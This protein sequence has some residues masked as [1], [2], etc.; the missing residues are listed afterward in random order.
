MQMTSPTSFMSEK[1]GG[2]VA[3]GAL[4]VL[5]VLASDLLLFDVEPGINLFVAAMLI[6][7]ALMLFA[8]R[9]GRL[10]RGVLG[11]ATTL[12][13]ALPLIEAPS[14]LGL[15][16]A[17]LG[18][19]LAALMSMRLVPRR[20][21]Q[22]PTTVMRLLLPAPITLAR[23]AASLGRVARQHS[24]QASLRGLLAWVMPLGLGVVFILLFAA[25]NPL[26]EMALA[27]LRVDS[28]LNLLNPVRIVFWLIM[29][30]GI[31]A[32]LRP[33]LLRWQKIRRE[34]SL[35]APR[36][37]AWFGH[38]AVIRAL[39][40]FNAL[41]A[42][43][44]ALDLAFLWG[45]MELP[46]SMSHAEYAHRGAYPLVFTALLA[47]A[48]VLVA[49]R[50]DGP[51]QKSRLIRALVYA[52]IAQNVLL[53]LSAMLRLKLYVEVYSL[54]ELRLAA[55]IWMGLVAAGLVFISLRI[56]WRKSN[57]WLVA[58]NVVALVF[59][60]HGA[61]LVDFSAVI[62]R[63]NV[64]HSLEVSGEGLALDFDYLEELGPT[65]IPALDVFIASLGPKQAAW[66]KAHNLRAKLDHDFRRPSP[67]WR[68]WSW[69]AHRLAEYLTPDPV[70]YVHSTLQNNGLM[71]R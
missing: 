11:A 16:L 42:V 58:L 51:G 38:A 26:I 8:A 37:T 63:F 66:E 48:F 20:L 22:L 3:A 62:A 10:G 31:W 34:T 64:E 53:C 2:P 55:G 12:V 50:R 13:F 4:T 69:R 44:T 35:F 28:A 71:P 15:A 5:L 60:L 9:R 70:A 18:L 52:F 6:S 49:M 54:T 24:W 43:E 14:L 27:T 1:A 25:A 17:G 23:D 21:E 57:T 30:A 41:F 40:V 56:W 33:R 67:E 61:A 7:I 47:G 46:T 65:V 29:A 19:A 39:A 45:G 59:V 32:L 68:S 36:E